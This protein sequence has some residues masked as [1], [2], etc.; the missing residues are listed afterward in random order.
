MGA[1]CY[2]PITQEAEA[3]GFQLKVS[4]GNRVKPCL[5][6]EEGVDVARY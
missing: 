4:L 6:K 1:Y 3:G 2:N 5:K